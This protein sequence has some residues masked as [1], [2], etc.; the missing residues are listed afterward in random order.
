MTAAAVLVIVPVPVA[1]AVAAQEMAVAEAGNNIAAEGEDSNWSSVEVQPVPPKMGLG[2]VA[3]MLE[4]H[5]SPVF[6]GRL[7]QRS[8]H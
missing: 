7:H 2:A 5:H 1:V 4:E 3:R 8:D 6:H